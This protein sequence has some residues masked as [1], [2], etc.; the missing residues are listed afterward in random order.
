M[1][2]IRRLVQIMMALMP[3]VVNAPLVMISLLRAREFLPA[4]L[5]LAAVQM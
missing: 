3:I 1:V 5:V 2:M 4:F